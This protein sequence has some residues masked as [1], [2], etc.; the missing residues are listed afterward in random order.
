[1]GHSKSSSKREVN[2]KTILPQ[3]IRK[4]SN[5]NLTLYLR[6]TEKEQTKSKVNRRKEIIRSRNK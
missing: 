6:Q 3:E 2:S 1:M 5:N 4:I